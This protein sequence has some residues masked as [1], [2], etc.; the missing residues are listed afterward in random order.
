MLAKTLRD[1]QQKQVAEKLNAERLQREAATGVTALTDCLADA[2]NARVAQ[3]FK[4][5]REIETEAKR[6]QA[7]TT[8]HGRQSRQW[9][10]LFN[11][12]NQALKDLGDV[13]SW[14]SAIER[15]FR[16]TCLVIEQAGRNGELRPPNPRRKSSR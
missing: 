6:L 16:D 11:D 5:Q 1:H 3:A 4:N 9:L 10:K 7:A 14:S 2:M 15:D 8:Q 12:F 13:R